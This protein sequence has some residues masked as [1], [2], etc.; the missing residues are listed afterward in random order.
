MLVQGKVVFDSGHILLNV[1]YDILS[2][3]P[4]VLEGAD[5]YFKKMKPIRYSFLLQK[6]NMH[7]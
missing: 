3:P 6:P 4:L 2:Q 1:K 7:I 5:L